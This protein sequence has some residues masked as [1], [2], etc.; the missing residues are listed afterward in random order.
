MFKVAD[1]VFEAKNCGKTFSARS[2]KYAFFGEEPELVIDVTDA[3]VAK[4]MEKHPGVEEEVFRYLLSGTAFYSALIDRNG[5][6]L[7][8]SAVVKDGRAYL[9]T[10]GSGT[11]KSTH[12]GYWLELFP[13][14][15]ILNDDKPAIRLVDGVFYA[16]G[17][18]WSG[19]FDL[20]RNEGVPIGG[21]AC[22]E[23]A[24]ENFIEPMPT[25]LAAAKLLSQTV[26]RV[27]EDRLNKLLDTMDLLIRAVPVYRL[28]CI[29]DRSAA[30]LSS[31]V[32]TA[33]PDNNR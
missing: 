17:T 9:F 24:K 7:H 25:A 6:L 26:R 8:S 18:P 27:S 14:A 1:I 4:H 22:V 10:A 23:R 29:A 20:S 21:I 30:E 33:A 5:M 13:D 32:M 15:Y 19:K 16:Y 2:L 11:G 31:K 12:T 3:E 28:G